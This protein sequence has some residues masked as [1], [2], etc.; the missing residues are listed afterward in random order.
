[1]HCLIHSIQRIG[2]P[3][4]FTGRATLVSGAGNGRRDR[5][6][7]DRHYRFYDSLL[8]LPPSGQ[9]INHT[10]TTGESSATGAS[11]LPSFLS[12]IPVAELVEEFSWLLLLMM[13]FLK[14]NTRSIL[15]H[16]LEHESSYFLQKLLINS[17]TRSFL[18]RVKTEAFSRNRLID[19]S[20]VFIVIILMQ[21]EFYI[22][23]T[24]WIQRFSGTAL[25]AY[26]CC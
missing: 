23:C 22:T 26:R 7:L 25:F 20:V 4:S 11:G 17:K 15:F 18:L 1:M 21:R 6:F 14:K 16:S 5:R 24:F 10:P 9:G 12:R 13:P 3:L 2:L 19:F 8:S